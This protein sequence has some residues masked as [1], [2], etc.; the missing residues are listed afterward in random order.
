MKTIFVDFETFYSQEYSLRKMTPVEYALDHRFECI[1]VAV[2]EDDGPSTF[3]AP[4]DF[5]SYLG[6]IKG[7]VAMVSHNALFDMCVLAWRYDFVPTLLIDTMG[8]ARAMLAHK[9]KSLSLDSVAQ[10]LG[11]GVKGSTVHNVK[12][13]S[14]AAIIAAGLYPS[15]AAYSCNDND[16][17]RGIYLTLMERGFP[18]QE[19]LVMDT[20]LRCAIV[21]KFQLDDH[22]L[23]EHL[24]LVLQGK[25]TLL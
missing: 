22:V 17:A 16:L 12:G 19:L 25:A 5:K 7:K 1:G 13:M 6:G 10:E 11:L 3:M 2:A 18:A 4:D 8:M 20:V 9:L 21:P 24:H 15:Y 23:A 14:R